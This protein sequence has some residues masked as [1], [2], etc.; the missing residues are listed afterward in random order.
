MVSM[1][2]AKFRGAEHCTHS[3][4]KLFSLLYFSKD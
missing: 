4:G 1:V 2:Y 3:I